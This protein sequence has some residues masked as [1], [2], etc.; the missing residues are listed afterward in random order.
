MNKTQLITNIC[1]TIHL[2][3]TVSK[4]F[5]NQVEGWYWETHFELD[6]EC[7]KQTS[8]HKSDGCVWEQARAISKCFMYRAALPWAVYFTLAEDWVSGEPYLFPLPSGLVTS[9]CAPCTHFLLTCFLF[10]QSTYK[11]ELSGIDKHLRHADTNFKTL[12]ASWTILNWQNIFFFL[13]WN[14]RIKYGIM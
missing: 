12:L 14:K 10:S 7:A 9:S 13:G 5:S 8:I 3:L 6:P 4:S 11:S 2:V 1:I